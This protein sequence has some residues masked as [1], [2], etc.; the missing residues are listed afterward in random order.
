[1]TEKKVGNKIKPMLEVLS[2]AE[3]QRPIVNHASGMQT[4]KTPTLAA[5]FMNTKI[6]KE[7][8]TDFANATTK[9]ADHQE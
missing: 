6:Q 2:D 4:R 7:G 1:M 3:A 5:V 9:K 8:A